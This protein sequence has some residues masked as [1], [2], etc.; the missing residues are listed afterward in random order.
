MTS[1]KGL[2][3]KLVVC[4]LGFTLVLA[5][6]FTF[7]FLYSISDSA[8]INMLSNANSVT[9]DYKMNND[10][11]KTVTVNKN[12]T[13][14]D[15]DFNGVS[16]KDVL[17]SKVLGNINIFDYSFLNSMGRLMYRFQITADVEYQVSFNSNKIKDIV[18]EKTTQLSKQYKDSNTYTGTLRKEYFSNFIIK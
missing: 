11:V 2:I 1:K 4:G 5:L 6:A 18:V 3:Y 16:L 9:F 17:Q 13:S 10:P 14:S 12:G 15:S 7:I 8:Y